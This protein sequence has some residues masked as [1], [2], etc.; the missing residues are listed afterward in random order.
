MILVPVK[1][2]SNAKQRLAGL[3]DAAQRT[4]LAHAML[5]DVLRAAAAY[6]EDDVSV[7]TS[8]PFTHRRVTSTG[9]TPNA[10]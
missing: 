2:L 4:Q 7:V 10:K 1:N 8:D 3:L 6:G 9:E 5:E